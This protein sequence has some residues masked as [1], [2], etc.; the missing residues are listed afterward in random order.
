FE[1]ADGFDPRFGLV[2]VDYRNENRILKDSA[3]WYKNVIRTNGAS[4]H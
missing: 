3:L 1:W 4:L 2:Y